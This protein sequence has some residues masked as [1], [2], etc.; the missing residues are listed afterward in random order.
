MT[1][2]TKSPEKTYTADFRWTISQ[3]EATNGYTVC[4][5]WVDGVKVSACN[6][7]GYDMKGTALGSWLESAFA[8]RLLALKARNMPK[9][10]HWQPDRNRR[11]NSK[12]YDKWC[13]KLDMES[14]GDQPQL[15]KLAKSGEIDSFR[16]GNKEL[17]LRPSLELF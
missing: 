8:D 17:I 7:G 16:V 3:A 14:E 4:S 6:G 15:P 5:L 11:C 10:S 13:E 9:Q 2:S 12:C 1:K